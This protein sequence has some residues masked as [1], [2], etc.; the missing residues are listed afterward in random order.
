MPEPSSPTV[1]RR[2]LAAELRRLRERADLTGEQVAE[3]MAWSTSKVS[4]IENART[5]PRPSEIKQLLLLYGVDGK[6]AEELVALAQEANRKGWWEAYSGAL[7][8][9][10]TGYIGLEAEATSSC[11]WAPEFVTGLVQTED[12][13]R[14][15][16]TS[17]ARAIAPVPPGEIQGRVEARM[18]R[19][20]IL[21]RDPPFE[22]NLVFDES[23]LLRRIAPDKVMQRQLDRLIE[24]SEL[25]TVT[26]QILP[27]DGPHAIMT[28]G[29]ILLQF[30]K[31]HEVGYHDVAC[32]EHL[33]G[34]KNFEE[35]KETYQYQLAFERLAELSLSPGRSL[36][37][38]VRAKGTWK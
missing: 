17:H 13:A 2:R 35:E 5:T 4:R 6:Y 29:F 3:R 1:R 37:A 10:H 9:A 23:V 31:V 34:A 22:L 16:I 14:A 25:E 30:G 27:L 38:I 28:G 18:I 24:V 36:D 32:L 11:H 33:T 7:P 15:L 26:L 20:K 8:D 21:E 12:Y 19:Q